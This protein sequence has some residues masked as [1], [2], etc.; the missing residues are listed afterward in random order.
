VVAF[1]ALLVDIAR[2]RDEEARLRAEL[3]ETQLALERAYLRP[4]YRA[5]AKV[6]RKLEAAPAGRVVMKGY[7]TVRGRS[8]RSA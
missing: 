5:R 6:V 7:R 8:S 4:T 1:A 2:L 3:H